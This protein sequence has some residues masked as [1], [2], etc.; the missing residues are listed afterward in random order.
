MKNEVAEIRELISVTKII[1]IQ[2]GKYEN[3]T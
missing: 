2:K 3:K 1:K